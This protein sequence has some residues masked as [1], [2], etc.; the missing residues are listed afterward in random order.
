[1][2][3]LLRLFGP[4]MLILLAPSPSRAQQ[5]GDARQVRTTAD[6]V[7]KGLAGL[8][9]ATFSPDSKLI[10]TISEDHTVRL[11]RV[12]TGAEHAVLKHMAPVASVAF[13]P[14]SSLVVTASESLG[15]SDGQ[16]ACRPERPS[17]ICQNRS[18]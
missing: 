17:R 13:S 4:L 16:G 12:T 8:K 1:V 5:T 10:A 9:S 2:V 3:W 14:D 15:D 11:W 7:L 18:L 6:V